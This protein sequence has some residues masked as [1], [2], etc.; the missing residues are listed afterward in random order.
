GE[1][2]QY[3]W[4]AGACHLHVFGLVK[5]FKDKKLTDDECHEKNGAI[6]GILALTWNLL[7]R[8][9]PEEVVAPTKAA[10]AA[11]GLPPMAS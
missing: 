2:I 4:N 6:L 3:G 8:T 1:M 5:N 7:I 9:L 10:I 11:S